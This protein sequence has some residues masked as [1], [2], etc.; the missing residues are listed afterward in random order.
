MQFL[1]GSQVIVR[2]GGRAGFRG[3]PDGSRGR[4]IRGAVGRQH[5]RQVGRE[6]ADSLPLTRTS[7]PGELRGPAVR[8]ARY[9]R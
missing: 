8:S 7:R 9:A 4:A 3:P 1:D 6:D 5:A 2:S